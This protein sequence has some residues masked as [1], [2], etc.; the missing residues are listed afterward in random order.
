[1]PEWGERVVAVVVPADPARPPTLD[2]LRAYAKDRLP[3]YA[4]PRE[5]RLLPRLPLLPNGKTDLA[6]LRTGT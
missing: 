3:A 1:D 4:A 2:Q 5:L 6:L